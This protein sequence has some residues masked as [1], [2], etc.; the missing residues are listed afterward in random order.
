MA[1]SFAWHLPEP[2]ENNKRVIH[3]CPYTYNPA[4][5]GWDEDETPP[6][7]LA[8]SKPQPLSTDDD[9]TI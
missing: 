5:P 2:H 8:A 4:K 7:G 6:N 3:G 9:P 1:V